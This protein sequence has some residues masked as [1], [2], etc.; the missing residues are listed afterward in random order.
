MKHY[1][2]D[3]SV[4]LDVLLK[5]PPWATDAT[6]IWDAHRNGRLRAMVAAFS[7]PTIFYIV[8]KQAGLPAAQAAVQACL[9]TLDVVPTDHSTLT[10]AQAL[11]GPDFEDNLQIAS[12]VQTGADAIVMR[13]PRGF[14]GSPVPAITP[15][16][17]V[18]AL[19]GPTSP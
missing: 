4:I 19:S 10:T 8:R 9:S 12:A 1:L 14:A 3:T 5:R 18:A 13:D 15:A 7:L 6:F 11:S 16:D 2:L 17:A